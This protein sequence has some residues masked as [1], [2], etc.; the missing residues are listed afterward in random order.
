[1]KNIE[2]EFRFKVEDE[3]KINNFLKRLTFVKRKTQNDIY[4]DTPLGDFYKKGIFMRNRNNKS[5]DFKFNLEDIENKHEE[6]E[7]FSF[8]L[9]ISENDLEKIN[10]VCKIIGLESLM[11]A[12][13]EDFLK[14]NNLKEL[15]IID[16]T[17][18]VYRDGIFSFCLDD[19]KG[20]G[21]FLEIE[22]M[23]D[24]DK[25]LESLKKTMLQKI[26]TL[27]PKL[28]PIGYIELFIKEKDFNLYKQGRFLLEEDN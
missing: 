13:L 12:N 1:M 7:E 8:S 5:L 11:T 18:D 23:L 16:K 3:E 2:V 28:L 9:P 14:T 20:F 22:T 25:N 27:N 26:S 15:V 21:K 10:R 24:D 19:I 4:F 17:R 6:C